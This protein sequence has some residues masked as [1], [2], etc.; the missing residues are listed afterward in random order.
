MLSSGPLAVEPRTEQGVVALFAG[1]CEIDFRLRITDIETG[2]PDCYARDKAGHEIGIEFEYESSRFSH[3]GA[4]RPG[5]S[6]R[7]GHCDWVVCWLDNARRGEK[8]RRKMKVVELSALPRFDELGP[9]VWIQPY[10]RASVAQLYGRRRHA[11]WTVPS[12]AR[13]GDLLVVYRSGP[14]AAVT[15]VMELTRGAEFDR[16][17]G[18]GRGF[19]ADLRTL[20]ELPN[21]VTRVD[22]LEDRALADVSFFEHPTPLGQ[23]VL[24]QWPAIERRLIR[25]NPGTGLK[26]ATARHQPKPRR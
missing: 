9:A 26:T 16:R 14:A 13:K 17:H 4:A 5:P 7:R 2:Y 3:A 11:Q 10:S 1:I 12:Q 21:P 22:L 25:R 6:G 18:W 24:E 19:H 20:V 15:H 23:N 8:W